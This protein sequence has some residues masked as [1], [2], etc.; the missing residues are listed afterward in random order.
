M[1]S[2]ATMYPKKLVLYSTMEYETASQN[3]HLTLVDLN[4]RN[5]TVYWLT[6][7]RKYSNHLV[8]PGSRTNMRQ[9]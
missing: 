1:D 3:G 2:I 8:L 5:D 7:T 9:D 4:T 6:A